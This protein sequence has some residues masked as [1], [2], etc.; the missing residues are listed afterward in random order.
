MNNLDFWDYLILGVA[1]LTGIVSL[2][3]L[4]DLLGS[5]VRRG[6]RVTWA[7]LLLNGF[8]CVVLGLFSFWLFEGVL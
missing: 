8:L 7:R 3:L 4:L 5:A 2:F 6:T 1:G